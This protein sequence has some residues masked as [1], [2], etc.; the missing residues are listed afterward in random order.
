MLKLSADQQNTLAQ[1]D[2][3]DG[4]KTWEFG[5][6]KAAK[7]DGLTPEQTRAALKIAGEQLGLPP[8]AIEASFV[9]IAS[10]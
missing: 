5:F 6:C 7:D 3:A 1:L 10:A 9:S 8:E 4:G 2:L